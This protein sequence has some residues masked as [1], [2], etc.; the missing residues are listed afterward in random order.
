MAVN[1]LIQFRRGTASQWTTTNPTLAQGEVGFETDTGKF[2]IGRN[3]TAWNSLPYA[4]GSA[5]AAGSGMCVAFDSATNSYTLSSEI[6]SSGSGISVSSLSCGTGSGN[7]YSISLNNR[8][9]EVSKLTSSGIVVSTNSSGV[10]TR[11][12]SSGNN[13]SITNAD[14]LGG[15]PIIA[16]SPS[17]TGISSIYGTDNN[18]VISGFQIN[19][20][21]G[22]FDTVNATSFVAKNIT[23]DNGGDLNY[24]GVFKMGTLF[25]QASRNVGM[26]SVNANAYISALSGTTFIDAS[27]IDITAKNGNGIPGTINIS[28][29]T[30]N[31]SG[32]TN[33][34]TLPLVNGIGV[35]LSGHQ[36]SYSDITNLCSG[37]AECVNTAIVADSGVQ[38]VYNSGLGPGGTL[39]IRLSGEAL[40]LNNLNTTGFVSRSGAGSYVTRTISGGSNIAVVNGDGLS[41]NPTISLSGN[42]SGLTSLTVDNLQLDGNTISSTNSN[43]DIV[44][45]PNGTG[46]VFVDAD[47]LRV[48]DAGSDATI[49]SNGAGN[50]TLN[51]NN[52]TNSS[53]ITIYDD[54]NGDITLNTNGTGEVNINKVDIDGGSIDGT[55][56]GATSAASGTFTSVSVDNLKLD[57][58]I[59]YYNNVARIDLTSSETV[60]NNPGNNTN[61]RVAGDNQTNLLFVNAETDR[62]GIGTSSPNSTLDVNGSGNFTGSVIIGGNLTVQGTTITA[63]VSSIE[64]EDP[65]LT[66]GLSSGNIITDTNLDRG[67]A[68]VRSSGT[69]AFM[70]WDSS[71]AQFVML[72]SG[73]A[74]NSSGNYNPGTYGNLQINNL[75]ANLGSFSD[76]ITISEGGQYGD[77]VRLRGN[78]TEYQG[79]IDIVFDKD[80]DGDLHVAYKENSLSQFASTSSSGLFGVMSNKTGSG[81]L[82]FNDSPTFTGVPL[83]PTA[84]SGTDT[85]QIASTKFVTTAL[86]NLNVVLSSG[87]IPLS[88]LPLASTTASGIA[89]FSSDNF[90]VNSSGLVTIKTSGISNNNLANNSITIGSTSIALGGTG[91]S[92]SG[93]SSLSATNLSGNGSG[94][95]NLNATNI[96][97]GTIGVNYLPTDIPI[98]NLAQSGIYFGNTNWFQALGSTVTMLRELTAISGTNAS[99]P[100]TLTYCSIDGGTP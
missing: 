3:A 47:T 73:L 89:I 18:S 83:A 99:S 42:V 24:S 27:G 57:N 38:T 44:L 21:T 55:T 11:S 25:M 93:L 41:G 60:I 33:F 78:S 98:T 74:A 63:N 56:I 32:Q 61:F 36:H 5:I 13:I 1:T 19:S 76:T 64:I 30:I 17:L 75:T 48:G 77:A 15:N 20:S 96:N 52:G 10:V 90:S 92:I 6:A 2:K 4:G 35:S 31:V 16:L 88:R 80:T 50:L 58:D 97:T 39:Y 9:Q 69:T 14:G 22:T 34:N 72:S 49:T 81:L 66:L 46:D 67:L 79:L 82:V 12:L 28:G 68:L 65:I 62:V 43:G 100:T 8:L 26:T 7:S 37:I 54:T 70:G 91:T 29:A 59:I 51:T 53:Y 95:T 85:D 86:N 45:A 40:A 87:P 71:A 84:A 23:I 94:I